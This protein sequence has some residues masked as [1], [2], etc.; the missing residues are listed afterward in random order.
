VERLLRGWDL[1]VPVLEALPQHYVTFKDML[2]KHPDTDSCC[3][4]YA[5]LHNHTVP[6]VQAPLCLLGL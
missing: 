4:R 1:L 6:G 5:T 3:C 2:T